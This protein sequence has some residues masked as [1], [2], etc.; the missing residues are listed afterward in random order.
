ML[1]YFRYPIPFFCYVDLTIHSYLF[2]LLGGETPC[3]R[4]QDPGQRSNK[5]ALY[6]VSSAL[7]A[8][9]HIMGVSQFFYF[10]S[11]SYLF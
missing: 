10:L 11:L 9:P 3:P 6:Q 5:N 4:I 7:T 1:V 8:T 2:I